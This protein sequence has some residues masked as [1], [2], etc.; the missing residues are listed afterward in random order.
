MPPQSASQDQLAGRL[1]PWLRQLRFKASNR[2]LLGP[3]ILDYG[4]GVGLYAGQIPPDYTYV[5]C[6]S[7]PA[8][9]AMARANDPS[10]TIIPGDI[11]RDG[12]LFEAYRETPFDSIVLLAVVEHIAQPREA[13]ARLREI[14]KPGG[15]LIMTT[16]A[17]IGK[18]VLDVTGTLGLS[19]RESHE[20]HQDLLG[21]ADLLD[22]LAATGY[23]LE[24]YSRFLAGLN[25]IVVGRN[26]R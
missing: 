3:R 13:L 17:P 4:C 23:Q 24:H 18:Q 7:N 16:P 21:K 12:E 26:G 11:V 22:L 25:Q 14:L 15:R 6:E 5:G 9:V 10:L 19:S 1:S 2:W 20:E 8:I